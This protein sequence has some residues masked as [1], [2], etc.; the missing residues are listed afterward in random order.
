[1]TGAHGRDATFET[2]FAFETGC[3]LFDGQPSAEHPAKGSGWKID[4]TTALA[5]HAHIGAGLHVMSQGGETVHAPW[6]KTRT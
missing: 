6:Y 3:C 5:L 2:P 1:M 4:L